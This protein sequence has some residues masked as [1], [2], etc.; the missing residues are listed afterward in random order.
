M[1]LDGLFAAGTLEPVRR[2]LNHLLKGIVARAVERLAVPGRIPCGVRGID[3]GAWNPTVRHKL[4]RRMGPPVMEQLRQHVGVRSLRAF[5]VGGRNR[6]KDLDPPHLAHEYPMRVHGENETHRRIPLLEQSPSG[7]EAEFCCQLRIGHADAKVRVP[8][9]EAEIEQGGFPV[10]L[11]QG[12]DIG[13][14]RG[15]LGPPVHGAQCVPQAQRDPMVPAVV[16]RSLG[17]E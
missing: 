2:R 9:T 11:T 16:R 15:E 12:L 6:L 5:S 7:M 13:P 3:M 1:L 14:Q 17:S 10:L 8:S 4:R